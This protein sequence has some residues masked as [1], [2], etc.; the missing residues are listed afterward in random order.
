MGRS[1]GWT[2]NNPNTTYIPRLLL[3]FSFPCTICPAPLKPDPPLP[4]DGATGPACQHRGRAAVMLENENASAPFTSHTNAHPSSAAPETE[5]APPCIGAA[6]PP[7]SNLRRT[8]SSSSSSSSSSCLQWVKCKQ[9]YSPAAISSS[10]SFPSL[11]AA[12][13]P[14]GLDAPQTSPHR[15]VSSSPAARPLSSPPLAEASQLPSR[16][17][18]GS[19][20]RVCKQ[21]SS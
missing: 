17:C 13:S 3:A 16:P 18:Q 5:T 14:S 8:Q 10:S 4:T 21:V 2:V 20:A 7:D 9:S 6:P 11:P 19:P 15:H 1:D 12:L